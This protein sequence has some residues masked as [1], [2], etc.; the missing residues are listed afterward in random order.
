MSDGSCEWT[1]I[2]LGEFA[3]DEF[4]EHL[5]PRHP[6]P[7]QSADVR[8]YG[9]TSG[10]SEERRFSDI[11][12]AHCFLVAVLFVFCKSVARI[13]RPIRDEL[14]EVIRIVNAWVDNVV[15]IEGTAMASSS[16]NVAIVFMLPAALRVRAG[17]K[18][19]VPIRFEMG[20]H[21]LITE[22]LD[23][24]IVVG[25][26]SATLTVSAAIFLHCEQR[27]ANLGLIGCVQVLIS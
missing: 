26:A 8:P 25:L 17:P 10:F 24:A 16:D 6:Q 22:M 15:H 18:K 13:Y 5:L 20:V 7:I 23:V 2:E 27:G 14:H 12:D 19:V 21:C 9:I 4:T 11:K 3:R 1:R